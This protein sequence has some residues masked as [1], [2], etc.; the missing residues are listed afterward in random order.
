MGVFTKVAGIGIAIAVVGIAGLQAIG[1]QHDAE[2]EQQALA[3]AGESPERAIEPQQVNA[4]APTSSVGAALPDHIVE[5]CKAS[6]A[7]MNDRDPTT[8]TGHK[9]ASGTAHVSWRSRDD[10]K[11]WQARCEAIDDNRLRWA[12][13]NAFGDGKQGRWRSEDTIEVSVDNSSLRI[14]LNQSG[15][16]RKQKSYPLSALL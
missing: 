12:A 3:E 11:R 15:A 14:N 2:F 6:I 13:F 9:I 8:F 5:A 10:N 16:I 7:L 4:V 1:N